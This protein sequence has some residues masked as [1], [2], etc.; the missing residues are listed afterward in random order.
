MMNYAIIMEYCTD[1]EGCPFQKIYYG[2]NGEFIPA[3]EIEIGS[4]YEELVINFCQILKNSNLPWMRFKDLTNGR[5]IKE[6]S[7][8][9]IYLGTRTCSIEEFRESAQAVY[10]ATE[11]LRI[12]L[13][14]LKDGII[15]NISRRIP[16]DQSKGVITRDEM[17]R[18]IKGI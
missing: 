5:I 6:K 13:F 8:N 1:A 16:F 12:S 10:E 2:V 4:E 14:T 15:T 9:S 17:Q 3:Y 18:L 7:F 11:K